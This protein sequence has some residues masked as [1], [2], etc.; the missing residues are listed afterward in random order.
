MR[1]E[2]RRISDLALS[3]RMYFVGLYHVTVC[4]NVLQLFRAFLT[5]QINIT[6][7]FPLYR[8]GF[9]QGMACSLHPLPCLGA[10]QCHV[11]ACLQH[12]MKTFGNWTLFHGQGLKSSVQRPNL[13]PFS[14]VCMHASKPFPH[15]LCIGVE[16]IEVI[17]L[18]YY[19]EEAFSAYV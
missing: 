6:V 4:I 5:G 10:E 12:S 1:C 11:I 18:C 19:T 17:V 15:F 9:S 8:K 3:V 16:N 7:C 14:S 2:K 13:A